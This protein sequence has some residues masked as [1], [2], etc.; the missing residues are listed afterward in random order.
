M[1]DEDK[2]KEQLISELAQLRR[3]I[4]ELEMSEAKRNQAEE[5]I[6][7][8]EVSVIL[9]RIFGDLNRTD[10]RFHRQAISATSR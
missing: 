8:G 2:T 4:A 7:R 5:E 1:K 9:S 10:N 3:Q 6:R